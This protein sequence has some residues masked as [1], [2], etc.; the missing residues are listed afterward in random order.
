MK[1]TANFKMAKQTKRLL[2]TIVD[3]TTRDLY[4]ANMIQAQLQ[5]EVKPVKEKSS[6]LTKGNKNAN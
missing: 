4:K 6:T 1:P 5:S 3:K 2:A